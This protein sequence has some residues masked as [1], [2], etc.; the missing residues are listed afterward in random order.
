MSIWQVL[1]I[2][3][4][5]LTGCA[6]LGFFFASLMVSAQ[7]ERDRLEER[8]ETHPL[9]RFLWFLSSLGLSLILQSIIHSAS[10]IMRTIVLTSFGIVWAYW[11][12]RT[13][14]SIWKN[15][16]DTRFCLR[17]GCICAVLTASTGYLLSGI[18]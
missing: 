4:T 5:A 7:E 18:N 3:C 6:A 15:H 12:I 11:F 16:R 14:V 13:L 10:S 8:E 17:A 1:L 2:T 9:K